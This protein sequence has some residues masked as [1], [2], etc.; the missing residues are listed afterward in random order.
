MYGRVRLGLSADF[1][2]LYSSMGD[3]GRYLDW[4]M[5]DRWISAF[6]NLRLDTFND[7]YFPTGESGWT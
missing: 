7:G 4:H 5:K 3:E 2:P 6:A 1:T